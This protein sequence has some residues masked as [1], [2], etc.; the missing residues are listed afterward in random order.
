VPLL[1][2]ASY[3]TQHRQLND[4]FA[5]EAAV[6]EGPVISREVLVTRVKE[7]GLKTWQQQWTNTGK[8]A[9]TKSFFPV[10]E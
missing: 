4:K 6:E 10:S 5:K 7:D 2:Y 9:V 3:S 8:G 1:Q